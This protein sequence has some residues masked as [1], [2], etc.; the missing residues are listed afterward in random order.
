MISS[1]EAWR[2]VSNACRNCEEMGW[3]I[4]PQSG[5]ELDALEAEA[6]TLINAIETYRA[7]MK[8]AG[9]IK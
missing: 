1:D 9:A 6:R 5:R 8:V 2:E 7:T 4:N 3:T